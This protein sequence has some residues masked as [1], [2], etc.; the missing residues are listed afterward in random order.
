MSSPSPLPADKTKCTLVAKARPP[1]PVALP[2]LVAP[3]PPP[4]RPRRR[5]LAGVSPEPAV[6]AA[7]M[8]SSNPRRSSSDH[9]A[10]HHPLSADEPSRYQCLKK[11]G[12]GAF[13]TVW[14]AQDSSNGRDVAV[15]V[16]ADPQ[17]HAAG[18]YECVFPFRRRLSP[19]W[20]LASR[21]PPHP[22]VL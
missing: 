15:K 22:L 5:T 19:G 13:A 14:L 4:L 8:A 21:A 9:A 2:S 10:A 20:P 7:A 12:T 6:A 18:Q 3:A 1:P 11:L 17:N 16:I